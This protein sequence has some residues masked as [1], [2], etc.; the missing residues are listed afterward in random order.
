M[1]KLV[2]L[3]LLLGYARLSM[4]QLVTNAP[5]FNPNDPLFQQRVNAKMQQTQM[6]LDGIIPPPK[7]G[8]LS[9]LAP[10]QDC[11]NAIPVCQQTYTQNVSYSGYGPFLDIAPNTTCL[12]TGETNSVWYI[13]TVQNSGSFIF[14]INTGQDYD[15]ALYNITGTNCS[16]IP[17][18]TP[19]RCNYSAQYGQTGL[20]LPTQAGNLSYD[21]S[22]SPFMPG[23]NVTAGQTYV[24]IVNNFTGNTTGYTLTFGGTASIFDQSAP[25]ITATTASCPPV[26]QVTLT[27]SE[28][29]RCN[30]ITGTGSEFS[31][32]GPQAVTVSSASGV[33]CGTGA[34]TNQLVINTSAITTPG[35]YTV[36]INNGTDGNT[37]LDNCNNAL[38][39]GTQV[40]FTVDPSVSISGATQICKGDNVTLTANPAGATSYTWNTGANT[41]A[42]T[43][44]PVVTTTYTVTMVA[45]GC[46]TTANHTVTVVD[47][48]QAFV[49]PSNV[50]ICGAGTTT[51]T[52][53]ALF[54][55]SAC[56]DCNYSWSHGVVQNG[57]PSSSVVVGPGYLYRNRNKDRF[58]L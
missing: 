57:V 16:A 13:F 45:N 5:P 51:L 27:F 36:T 15:F 42:I 1:K 49:T 55:G 41:Q 43:V 28:N 39:S 26:N 53:T 19:V 6:I 11:N 38:T 4:A 34:F 9:P 46:T 24:L 30:S 25:T 33:S 47:D 10:E 58:Y 8:G 21:A 50:T 20:T 35:T 7:G 18:L 31:I 37:F 29:V 17:S 3:F 52:A 40:T 48:I 22:Q 54:G 12:L 23:I 44:S 32:T 14:T 56:P 2:I